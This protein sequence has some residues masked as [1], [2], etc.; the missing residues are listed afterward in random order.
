MITVSIL[1]PT[2]NEQATILNILHRVND[3]KIEGV[4]FEIIV[5]DDGSSDN[6]MELLEGNPGLYSQLIRREKN[7]GK[8]AAIHTGLN[9]ATGDFIL[10][11]DA[12]LEYDPADYGKLL[13]PILRHG[14]EVVMGSRLVASEYT[15][16]SY[17]WHRVG[18]KLITFIF[19]IFNNTTFTDIYSC[20][21]V[22]RRALLDPGSLK[23]FGWEQQAEIL[24]RIMKTAKVIYEVPI[25][26][27][28]RTYDEG[29]KIKAYHAIPVIWTILWRR[30]F[31]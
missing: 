16:V 20:Y 26:Y 29:K 5:I 21:L 12:D 8:G 30:I 11:Q 22:Y 23:T 19:N 25:S 28:G 18:N 6:T 17:F 27:H 31:R 13:L 9:A 3:Q 14:A 2:Y 4:T 7:G 15:R 24:S 1:I 10:F